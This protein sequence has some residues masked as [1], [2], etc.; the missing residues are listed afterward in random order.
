[1]RHKVV[2]RMLCVFLCLTGWGAAEAQKIITYDAGMGSRD[3]ENPDI[4]ILYKRVR[5]EHEGMVLYAD[6]ALLN[7][8]RDPNNSPKNYLK[9]ERK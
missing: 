8:K 2:I 5:A 1:M 7:T 6:S 4:W 9:S 3:P